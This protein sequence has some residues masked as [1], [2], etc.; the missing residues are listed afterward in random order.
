M[1]TTEDMID[2]NRIQSCTS[3]KQAM[4]QTTESVTGS[5]YPD[6]C[7]SDGEHILDQPYTC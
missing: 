6:S 2:Q 7:F 4:C 5:E 3:M 1:E